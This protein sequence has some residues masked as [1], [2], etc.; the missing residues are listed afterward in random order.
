MKLRCSQFAKT[1][2]ILFL[3]FVS[4]YSFSASLPKNVNSEGH[5]FNVLMVSSKI[6]GANKCNGHLFTNSINCNSW[7]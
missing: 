2:L 6:L 4:S 5:G 3:L 1:V 7:E